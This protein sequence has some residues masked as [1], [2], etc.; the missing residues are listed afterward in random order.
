[1]ADLFRRRVLARAALL[2]LT[3]QQLS[4]L[5]LMDESTLSR[6]LR[7]KKPRKATL[8]RISKGLDLTV[9]ELLGE[10]DLPIIRP[11]RAVKDLS[12][13]VEIQIQRWLEETGG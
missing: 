10:D 5:L 11:H 2:G 3:Q 4:R 12:M 8:E 9:E 1:L 6:A 13:D 7:A